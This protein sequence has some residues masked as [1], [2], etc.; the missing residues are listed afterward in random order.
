MW[1]G[2]F[3]WW[4]RR[5]KEGEEAPSDSLC[6]MNQRS[7]DLIGDVHGRADALKRLLQRLGYTNRDGV[8]RHPERRVIFLGDFVDRGPNQFETIEIAR[9]MVNEGTA[10][11]IMGNHEF[12]AIGWFTEDPD[13]PGSYLRSRS[14]KNTRQ[15]K[16]FRR[17]F[18]HRPL[19]HAKAIEWFLSLPLWL[20]M[21]GLRVV[22]ACWQQSS[23]DY[24]RSRLGASARLSAE[25]LPEVYC[26]DGLLHEHVELILKGQE[27]DLPQGVTR[28]DFDGLERKSMRRRWWDRNA[29]TYR[30]SVVLRRGETTDG[31]P[32]SRL[33]EKE[34]L[35]VDDR[36]PTFFGHYCLDEPL[37]EGRFVC[38][39]SCAAG[40]N[41]LTAY[42]WDGEKD[43]HASKLVSVSI[44][45]G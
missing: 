42:R 32:N 2:G 23:I 14:E 30:L 11:A 35:P 10:L 31:L 34:I 27:V 8:W 45:Q 6:S 29:V 21:D 25:I 28:P 39:D 12:N 40:G 26:K 33:P 17:E 43:L 20:E 1:W 24:L 15:N 44:Q 18:E 16:A 19:E 38:L 7:F 5:F 9:T 41:K 4:W 13:Q 22:H 3:V 36:L 37:L